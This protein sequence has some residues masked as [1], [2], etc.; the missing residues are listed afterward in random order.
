MKKTIS[1][2][3]VL[4]ELIATNNESAVA[5]GYAVATNDIKTA[6]ELQAVVNTCRE[7][8]RNLGFEDGKDFT[9][10]REAKKICDTSFMWY[11]VV[12]E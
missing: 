9:V 3:K 4:E 6:D 2:R 1:A 10:V 5:H 8:M 12:A 7:L 11:R